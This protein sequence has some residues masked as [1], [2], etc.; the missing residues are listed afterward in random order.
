MMILSSEVHYLFEK[1]TYVWYNL[2][3]TKELHYYFQ[4]PSILWMDLLI[5]VLFMR[6]L[7]FVVYTSLW[8][9]TKRFIIYLKVMFA[10]TWSKLIET[11][12]KQ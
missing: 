2:I 5:V 6:F 8:T 1:Q 12:K 10:Y 3:Y 7:F 4:L 9:L 11:K